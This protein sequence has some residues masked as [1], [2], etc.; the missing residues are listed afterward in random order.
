MAK[1]AVEN[2]GSADTPVDLERLKKALGCPLCGDM[3]RFPVTV[4]RSL[5]TECTLGVF[6]FCVS[7]AP[8]SARCSSLSLSV[9]LCLSLSLSASLCVSLCLSV[10]VSFSLSCLAPLSP[11]RRPVSSFP[12]PRPPSF[13]S[14]SR[15]IY[16]NEVPFPP[17]SHAF[18]QN[19]SP[20]FI[21][22]GSPAPSS[23]RRSSQMECLH[24]FC[25]ECIIK[26]V[27]PGKGSN[28]CPKVPHNGGAGG[29]G[30]TE[31]FFFL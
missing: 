6:C 17:K 27:Q 11:K 13:L 23:S 24:T 30:G 15:L 28:A 21:T 20:K 9:S 8:A 5:E 3:Y 29:G 2:P 31:T 10:C 14:S 1:E 18:S 16:S 19:E 12:H 4:V 22:D 26:V 25:H 7:P